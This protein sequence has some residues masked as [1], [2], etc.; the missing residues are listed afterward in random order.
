MKLYF[1]PGAC[2]LATHIILLEV[3]AA[4]EL[5]QVDNRAKTTRSGKD[6]LEISPKGYVPTLELDNGEVLTENPVVLQYIGDQFPGSGVVPL[7]G[8]FDRYR[9][10][11]WLNYITSEI[12]PR[13]GELFHGDT[14]EDYKTVVRANLARR[15]EFVEKHLAAGHEYLHGGRFGVA[16]AYLFVI[17]RW[18]PKVGID[19][20]QWPKLNAWWDRIAMRPHVIEA[21]KVEGLLK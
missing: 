12:H 19:R 9:V 10:M 7:F 4:F 13:Y 17:S 20:A 3:G 11:E 2:S 5:D 1:S 18:M 21:M 15:Y 6:F 8:T 16:D 14:P